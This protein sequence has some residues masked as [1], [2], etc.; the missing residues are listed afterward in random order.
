MAGLVRVAGLGL[1]HE[2]PAADGSCDVV[3]QGAGSCVGAKQALQRA[4]LD[5]AIQRFTAA[6]WEPAS[7][8]A[9]GLV[10]LEVIIDAWITHLRDGVF[11][12]G[13]AGSSSPGNRSRSNRS[14]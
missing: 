14:H 8:S 7:R 10:R 11:P 3:V 12:G 4:V 1:E 9:P 5:A 6:V 2:Q 13:T